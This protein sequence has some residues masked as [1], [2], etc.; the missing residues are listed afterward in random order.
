LDLF[1]QCGNFC[2]SFY[3]DD[4]DDDAD[5]YDDFYLTNTVKISRTFI[6]LGHQNNMSLHKDTL[7]AS[8]QTI[9]G[10]FPK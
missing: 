10:N 3:D 8:R 9:L 2:F 5:D 7:S 4:D 1:R 6:M